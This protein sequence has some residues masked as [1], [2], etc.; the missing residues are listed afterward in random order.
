MSED[1]GYGGLDNNNAAVKWRVVL[2]EADGSRHELMVPSTASVLAS[3][4]LEDPNGY[5]IVVVPFHF[6]SG[7]RM[8]HTICGR[9]DSD[10]VRQ[11]EW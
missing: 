7:T 3:M 11:V 8:L 9:D 1:N 2:K 5:A 4:S 10:E 6:H